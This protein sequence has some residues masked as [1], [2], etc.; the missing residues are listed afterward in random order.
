MNFRTVFG[1]V[2]VL[3]MF[4]GLSMSFSLFWSLTL[5]EPDAEAILL[6]IGMPVSGTTT[7]RRSM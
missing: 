1:L 5:G 4:I 7:V 3:I 6:S 2:G